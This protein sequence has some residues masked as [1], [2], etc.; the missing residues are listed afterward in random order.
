MS[1]QLK[2]RA[3]HT[4]LQ[5]QR[6]AT[7]KPAALLK[8]INQKGSV[9]SNDDPSITWSFI[10]HRAGGPEYHHTQGRP[11]SS[12]STTRPQVKEPSELIGR[13]RPAGSGCWSVARTTVRVRGQQPQQGSLCGPPPRPSVRDAEKHDIYNL[14][15]STHRNNGVCRWSGM[16]HSSTVK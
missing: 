9:H 15:H 1:T 7:R 2:Q 6:W 4:Q 8:G 5:W 14:A 3:V 16:S 13:P 11:E 10:L 12:V